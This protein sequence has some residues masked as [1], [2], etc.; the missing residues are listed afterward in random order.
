[1]AQS[2]N[3]SAPWY[4]S[5]STQLPDPGT[6]KYQLASAHSDDINRVFSW[7]NMRPIPG[8]TLRIVEVI[9]NPQMA[10][11]FEGKVELLQ[12]RHGNPAFAPK[13]DKEPQTTEQLSQRQKVIEF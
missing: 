6:K 7:F 1:M 4:F 3:L 5:P 2:T 9:H 10:R 13:W 12:E 8:M 11:M